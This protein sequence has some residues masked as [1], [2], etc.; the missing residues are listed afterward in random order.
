M[1]FIAKIL[2][3]YIFQIS[4]ACLIQVSDGLFQKQALVLCLKKIKRLGVSFFEF[5]GAWT[6][7]FF[8]KKNQAL[9]LVCLFSRKKTSAWAWFFIVSGACKRLFAS[10][11]RVLCQ[12]L[13]KRAPV[14]TSKNQ[15]SITNLFLTRESECVCLSLFIWHEVAFV[16]EITTIPASVLVAIGLTNAW[17]AIEQIF[18]GPAHTN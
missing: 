7:L 13:E 5:S 6:C 12:A 16:V 1:N 9:E 3:F 18:D 14:L 2:S 8:P 11:K 15:V 17:L 4:G 10:T